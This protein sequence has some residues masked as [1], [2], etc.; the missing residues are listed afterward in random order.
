MTDADRQA[1]AKEAATKIAIAC[2]VEFRMPDDLGESWK[3]ADR[4]Y[5]S[6]T[7]CQT[8]CGIVETALHDTERTV[9]REAVLLACPDC[10]TGIAIQKGW[11]GNDGYWHSSKQ[12]G[13]WPCKAERFRQRA[14]EA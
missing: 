7:V 14:E 4:E 9:W 2:L 11:D 8:A 3:A 1:R 10:A 13:H 6:S 5:F 12:K